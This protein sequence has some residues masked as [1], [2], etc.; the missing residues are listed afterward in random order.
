[1][2]FILQTESA[3]HVSFSKF[4]VTAGEDCTCRVWE[5]DGTELR[6]I[7]EHR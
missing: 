7:K 1:M 4:I 5:L 2:M 3:Q 6:V